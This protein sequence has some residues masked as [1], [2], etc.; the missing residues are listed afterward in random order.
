[1]LKTVFK[2]AVAPT[3][4]ENR[5]GGAVE[6]GVDGLMKGDSKCPTVAKVPIEGY[7]ENSISLKDGGLPK[8]VVASSKTGY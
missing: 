3:P 2:D 1:M 4:P 8:K 6:R 5:T 7:Q